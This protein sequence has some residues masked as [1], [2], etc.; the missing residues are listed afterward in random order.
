MHAQATT[1]QTGQRSGTG[2][3]AAQS[4]GKGRAR[5]R[6]MMAT[7]TQTREEWME[8][9]VAIYAE[10]IAFG[11]GQGTPYTMEGCI[12]DYHTMSQDAWPAGHTHKRYT[13]DK[14]GNDVVVAL[15]LYTPTDDDIRHAFARAQQMADAISEAFLAGRGEIGR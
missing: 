3:E 4:P 12:K 14:E 2:R 6:V 1:G 13:Q 15:R 9:Y 7:H 11:R 10:G 5:G 8:Q